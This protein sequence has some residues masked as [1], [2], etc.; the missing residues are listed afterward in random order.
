MSKE[1]QNKYSGLLVACRVSSCLSF[2][3]RVL[4]SNHLYMEACILLLCQQ[5]RSLDNLQHSIMHLQYCMRLASLICV[6]EKKIGKE[7]ELHFNELNTSAAAWSTMKFV[8]FACYRRYV[9][10]FTVIP[11]KP[12]RNRNR[13]HARRRRESR[14][15]TLEGTA[16]NGVHMPTIGYR[17]E[18]INM[19]VKGWLMHEQ[20]E[21]SIEMIRRTA[22]C[23]ASRAEWLLTKM[24]VC[25]LEDEE[26]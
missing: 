13:L 15:G 5:C 4:L 6:S 12:Q 25:E 19:V 10:K 24:G 2:C 3:S 18:V 8:R 21:I 11:C 1:M 14:Q 16:H 9:C 20:C 17:G 7:V 23:F 26:V 22:D